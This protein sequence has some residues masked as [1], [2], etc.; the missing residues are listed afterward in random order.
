MLRHG[1]LAHARDRGHAFE[2][3]FDE[4]GNRGAVVAVVVEVHLHDQAVFRL[5]S[6][7]DRLGRLQAPDEERGSR[8]D[9][10]RQRDLRDHQSVAQT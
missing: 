6:E 5:E 7:I 4:E 3:L 9:D 2:R 8:D 1:R 10:E